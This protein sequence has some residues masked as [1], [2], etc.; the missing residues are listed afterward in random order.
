MIP[1]E[2]KVLVFEL[3]DVVLKSWWTLIAGVCL[4]VGVALLVLAYTPA[5]YEATARLDAFTEMLPSDIVRPT[6]QNDAEVR[7]KTVHDQVMKREGLDQLVFA[8]VGEPATA[9][10]RKAL[11]SR[12]WSANVRLRQRTRFFEISYRDGDRFRAAKVANLLAELFIQ[13]NARQREQESEANTETLESLADDALAELQKEEQ[14]VAAHLAAH[15]YETSEQLPVNTQMLTQRRDDLETN[16]TGQ[17]AVEERI[18]I[19]ESQRAERSLFGGDAAD[20]APAGAEPAARDL[21]LRQLQQELADLRLRYSDSH[22]SVIAVKRQIDELLAEP[23]PAPRAQGETRAPAASP[24][25]VRDLQ[26]D[27]QLRAAR[28]E[29]EELRAEERAIRR[30]IAMY[31]RR[32]ANTPGVEARLQELSRNVN[33]RRAK[34]DEYQRKLADAQGALKVESQQRGAKFSVVDAA[35]P[36][37]A[38]VFPNPPLV[39]GIGVVAGLALFVGPALFRRLLRPLVSSESGL[40]QLA[41]V[42][43]LVTIPSIPSPTRARTARRRFMKNLG[44]SM[45]SM[46]ALA[47]VVVLHFFEKL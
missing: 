25:D 27:L 47:T 32:I 4:G 1:E 23:A 9:E 19:I 26:Y 20:D 3:L 38:P 16:R 39:L 10:E 8:R 12:V 28:R 44:L 42:P 15:R 29:L 2:R 45:A 22:P 30:D 31:E 37:G 5:I 17:L 21:R 14:Q 24:T 7:L 13:E 18:Q 43:V 33:V 41:E 11:M 35:S 6:V 40:R 36:P 46:A 34:F